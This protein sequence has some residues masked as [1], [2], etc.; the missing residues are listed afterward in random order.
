M[1]YKVISQQ[2]YEQILINRAIGNRL[3]NIKIHIDQCKKSS[4]TTARKPSKKMRNTMTT[5]TA[6]SN[7]KRAT[8]KT[9]H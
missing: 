2:E 1:E 5:K 4:A 3:N 6:F 8:K 7:A 9:Q